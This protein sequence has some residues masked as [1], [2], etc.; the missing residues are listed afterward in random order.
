M[1]A[2]S[3]Q[4][5]QQ[6]VALDC[7][8]ALG[9]LA[10]L[11][12]R[13]AARSLPAGGLAASMAAISAAPAPP[14]CAYTGGAQRRC[15]APGP[16]RTDT[17]VRNSILSRARL[18]FRHRGPC[19]RLARAAPASAEASR[20]VAPPG[21]QAPSPVARRLAAVAERLGDM[22]PARP[23]RHRPDRRSSG[24]RAAPGGSRAPTGASPRPHRP[25]ACGPGSSGVATAS[26]SSPSASALVRTPCRLVAARLHARARATRLATSALP[27]AGGGRVEVGGATRRRPRRAGR[28]GRAAARHRA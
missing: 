3:G 7:S 17:P 19:G 27:S 11:R 18:P 10:W 26:S 6:P 8:D 22:D 16:T 15:G 1:P 20:G 24:R 25:A 23:A 2:I 28:S 13:A 5:G 9:Q 4:R 14:A 12:S 21:G